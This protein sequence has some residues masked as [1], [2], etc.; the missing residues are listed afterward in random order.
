[1]RNPG[2]GRKVQEASGHIQICLHHGLCGLMR[3]HISIYH[4][5]RVNPV[6]SKVPELNIHYYVHI[7]Y[8]SR[9]DLQLVW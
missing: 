6:N 3:A 4:V 1:M 8:E 7:D 9:N 2:Q 5:M